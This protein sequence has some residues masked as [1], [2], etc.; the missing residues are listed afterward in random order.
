LI[1]SLLLLEPNIAVSDT[2]SP[3]RRKTRL[4]LAYKTAE[5]VFTT[6]QFMHDIS[7]SA[8]ERQ[9]IAAAV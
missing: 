3:Q 7:R 2:Q 9:Q 4:N 5:E 8:E 1:I 6:V